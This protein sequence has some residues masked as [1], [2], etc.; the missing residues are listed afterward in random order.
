MFLSRQLLQV[1]LRR[2]EVG[3]VEKHLGLANVPTGLVVEFRPQL[4]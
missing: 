2:V 1:D 3:V 4:P